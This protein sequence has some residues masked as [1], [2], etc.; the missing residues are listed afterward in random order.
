MTRTPEQALREAE[1]NLSLAARRL[2]ISRNT[3]YRR[4]MRKRPDA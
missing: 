3:F 4:I 1:G 2:G